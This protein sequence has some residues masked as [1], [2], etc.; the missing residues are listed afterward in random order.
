MNNLFKE[1]LLKGKL[2]I[3]FLSTLLLFWLPIL[4]YGFDPHHDGLIVATV[5]NLDFKDS[6]APFNQYGPIWFLILKCITYLTPESYFFLTIRIVTLAFYW[7]SFMFTYFLANRFL[8]R[9]LSIGVIILLLAIQPFITDFNSDMIPW[10]SALS[11]CTVPLLGMLIHKNSNSYSHVN[12]RYKMWFSGLLV[13]VTALTRVQI[14]LALGFSILLILATYRRRLELFHF[15]LGLSGTSVI[16]CFVF[17]KLGWLDALITDMLVFGSTYAFGDRAT[18]PKPIWTALLTLLF[19]GLYY[20]SKK[21]SAYRST[22]RNNSLLGVALASSLI[23][24]LFV[25]GKRDL[26]PVHL[27]TV[28]FRR[29]WISGL[30]AAIVIGCIV[31]ITSLLQ[32]REL[33]EF[34]FASLVM[35]SAVAELQVWPLF[36]QMHAWWGATPGVILGAVILK[37]TTFFRQATSLRKYVFEFILLSVCIVIATITFVSSVN[38]VRVNLPISGFSGILVA[39]PEEVELTAVDNFLASAVSTDDVVLNLCTNAN[40]FFRPINVPKSAARSFIF[41]TPMF[42][43]AQLRRD[44]LESDPTKVITCSFVTNPIFYP[45]YRAKQIEVLESFDLLGRVPKSFIS[46]NGVIWDVYSRG[47]NA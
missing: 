5:N 42:D 22:T 23:F 44:I 35:L 40:I 31:L 21:Y 43:L 18:Y 20:F 27:L 13:L 45:E 15:C 37:S 8:S 24:C 7:L 36:D 33:P 4:R 47:R 1:A 2:H 12:T 6:A 3:F 26:S 32:S 30:L 9:R 41:W 17:L 29:F 38:H 39:K 16:A 28:L 19:I 14:G 11:M 34:N 25:L 46:P 10:P